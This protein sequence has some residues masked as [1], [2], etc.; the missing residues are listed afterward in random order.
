[1]AVIGAKDGRCI[2]VCLGGDALK[3]GLMRSTIRA[4]VGI[5]VCRDGEVECTVVGTIAS[6]W[7]EILHKDVEVVL[8]NEWVGDDNSPFSVAKR[9]VLW[10]ARFDPVAG[11][12]D[13]GVIINDEVFC[14][15][16]GVACVDVFF[17]VLDDCLDGCSMDVQF[18]KKICFALTDPSDG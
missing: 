9:W 3:D 4:V 11:F 5:V 18:V 16:I 8:C 17:G 12:D 6:L 13:G 1:M 14:M 10:Y 7:V 2:K 15:I